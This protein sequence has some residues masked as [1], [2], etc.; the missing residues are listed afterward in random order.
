MII[1]VHDSNVVVP[2]IPRRI[3]VVMSW[4]SQF[5]RVGNYRLNVWKIL[6]RWSYDLW[7]ETETA[8]TTVGKGS[9][10][11]DNAIDARQ[12]AVLHLS[13]ILPKAQAKRLLS[14]QAELAWEPYSDP[15]SGR[16]S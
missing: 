14:E 11:Y 15:R 6:G 16:S 4:G 10:K 3:Q 13:N 12:A 5:T 1:S 9:E 2:L 7:W 8:L